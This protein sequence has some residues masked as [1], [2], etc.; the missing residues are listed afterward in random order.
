[1][2]SLIFTITLLLMV[3]GSAQALNTTETINMARILCWKSGVNANLTTASLLLKRVSEEDLLQVTKRTRLLAKRIQSFLIVSLPAFEMNRDPLRH[4]KKLLIDRLFSSKTDD[5]L[6]SVVNRLREVLPQSHTT[7][8]SID[9]LTTTGQ[10][11]PKAWRW[12]NWMRHRSFRES[13]SALHKQTI[14]KINSIPL[15]SALLVSNPRILQD[16]AECSRDASNWE[17]LDALLVKM[18]EA[19]LVG[20]AKYLEIQGLFMR[21][22]YALCTQSVR[23]YYATRPEGANDDSFCWAL[24]YAQ[25]SYLALARQFASEGKLGKRSAV[26]EAARQTTITIKDDWP[27]TSWGRAAVRWLERN[28]L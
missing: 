14:I 4:E 12:I 11:T 13:G 19:G 28:P 10:V 15:T 20:E 25:R 9:A 6:T 7:M 26:F 16:L 22:E 2:R 24:V 8:V 3:S 5:A 27:N 18:A 21:K 1:M 17:R 23:T